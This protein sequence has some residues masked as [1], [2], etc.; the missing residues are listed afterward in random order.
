MSINKVTLIGA[1]GRDPEYKVT[2]NGISM[3]ILSLAT[4]EF[5][6]DKETGNKNTRTEWHRVVCF[7]ER[8]IEALKSSG[9]Q[10]GSMIYAE[11]KIR[12]RKWDKPDGTTQYST[13]IVVSTYD[14]LF[15]FRDLE[16][17]GQ[18]AFAAS[19]FAL[20]ELAPAT[21]SEDNE[22]LDDELPFC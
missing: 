1:L 18:P 3:A 13:Q 9:A 22:I 8:K 21:A 20:T 11:G 16:S 10:T 12:Y 15:K 5:W 19:D 6:T 2:S 17:T 14:T 7:S 4:N